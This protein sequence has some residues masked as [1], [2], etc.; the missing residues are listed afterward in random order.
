MS[1]AN[2]R[3]YV[4]TSTDPDTGVSIYDVQQALMTSRQDL[5]ELC[6]HKNINRWARYKPE[7]YNSL[8]PITYQTRKN[9]NFGLAVPYCIEWQDHSWKQYVM[10][11]IVSDVM[12]GNYE[13][14]EYLKP[15]GG[16]QEAYRLTDFVRHPSEMTEDPNGDPTFWNLKGYNHRAKV[17][18]VSWMDG[19]GV[20]EMK[21]STRGTWY[22]IN[23]QLSSNLTIL[24]QNSI[25][26]D[27]HLQDFITLGRDASGRCWRPVL[28]VF[29]EVVGEYWD[30]KERPNLQVAGP[31]ITADGGGTVWSVSL[32]LSEQNGF[33][34]DANQMYHLCIGIGYVDDNFSSWGT[35]DGTSLFILP[36]SEGDKA[37]GK[38]PF[39][40]K[41][42]VTEHPAR[43]IKFTALQ[44]HNG[45][46]YVAATGTP[47]Y[48]DVTR[49]A[50]NGIWTT[51]TITQ[52]PTQKLHFIR[53]NGTCDTG[54]TPLWIRVK[55]LFPSSSS[56]N[57]YYLTPID[58]YQKVET[59]AETATATIYAKSNP[60]T[61]APRVLDIGN[62]PE[63]ESAQYYVQSRIGNDGE[64][65]DN[66]FFRIR[67]QST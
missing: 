20:T 60:D 12:N 11:G 25:G 23:R 65:V 67:K 22:E 15:R 19:T 27:L 49:F 9:N 66:G 34:Q 10:N 2:G 4:D 51:M 40:Y 3:I 21:N 54:Y 45:S 39:Y 28:Q 55:E 47:P 50:D 16:S 56:A 7:R 59:G 44:W 64:W 29:K 8:K 36:F 26:D 37:S 62:I 6:T 61:S 63:G 46:S 38:Y 13:P 18:F 32:D 17:P 5:G 1:Y 53:E 14:W 58:S 30:L 42:S 57:T 48:F 41:F 31:A 43:T 35:S 24:F 52:N 33:H